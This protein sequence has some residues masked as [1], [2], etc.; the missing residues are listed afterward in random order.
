VLHT[1]R[2]MLMFRREQIILQRT[3]NGS[4]A[5]QFSISWIESGHGREL[6]STLPIFRDFVDHV[7][8][9]WTGIVVDEKLLS[10]IR[11]AASFIAFLTPRTWPCHE[12]FCGM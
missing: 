6:T 7:D 2:V 9:D 10:P 4:A 11:H 1:L 5:E 3:D 8:G 12:C